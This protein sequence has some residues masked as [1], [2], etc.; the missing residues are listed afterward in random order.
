[1]PLPPPASPSPSLRPPA[2]S[3]RTIVICWVGS[4]LACAVVWMWLEDT[5]ALANMVDGAV[6]AAV[7]ATG[8]ALVYAQGLV[9]FQPR[10]HWALRAWRPLAQFGPDLWMLAAALVSALRSGERAPGALQ[11]VRFE[12]AG[13]PGEVSAR[14]AL[15][16]AVG[17]FA[18]NTIVLGVQARDEVMLVHQLVPQ[19]GDRASVDPLKLG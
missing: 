10:A 8:T 4:W 19:P 5:V 16:S 1:M 3:G 11:A 17:S 2:P 12:P 13:E 18:P 6:A 9:A 14:C 7:G 15:A